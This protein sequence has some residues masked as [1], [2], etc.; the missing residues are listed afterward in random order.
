M[1]EL[2][3]L[4]NID[5]PR[6][7]AALF[8]ENAI[9]IAQCVHL[10]VDVQKSY[11]NGGPEEKVAVHIGKDIAPA[12]NELSMQTYWIYL[13]HTPWDKEKHKKTEIE[14]AEL[15]KVLPA[16]NDRLFRKAETSAFKYSDLDVQLGNSKV[17]FVT[18]FAFGCCVQATVLE[19]CD[20]GYT[21]IVL[22]D[23]TS[24]RENSF[25]HKRMIEKG[26]IFANSNVIFPALSELK[27]SQTQSHP[28]PC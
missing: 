4:E 15:H 2:K 24:F 13:K 27:A 28:A 20:K 25:P 18:G 7:V 9:D 12:F 16:A 23:G 17:L 26:V 11:C 21:V 3:T 5:N 14:Y 22:K 8:A 6:D 19:A 10:A 1:A